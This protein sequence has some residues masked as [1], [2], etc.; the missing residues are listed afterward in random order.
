[1]RRELNRVFIVL[2][3]PQSFGRPKGVQTSLPP[4]SLEPCLLLDFLF[5]SF[6][7]GLRVRGRGEEL[8]LLLR[9]TGD[10]GLELLGET[11]WDL[12]EE[13]TDLLRERCL[14]RGLSGAYLRDLRCLRSGERD[15]RLR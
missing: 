8:D 13:D 12:L 7:R 6:E 9:R 14:R 15:L 2:T 1:M 4:S 11:Y 3:S 10:R 5:Y